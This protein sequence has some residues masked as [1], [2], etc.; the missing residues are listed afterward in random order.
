MTLGLVWEYQYEQD[1]LAL[2]FDYK[3]KNKYVL[4]LRWDAYDWLKISQPRP[5]AKPT[6]IGGRGRG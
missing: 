1:L 3:L 6:S 2:D 4:D 5:G